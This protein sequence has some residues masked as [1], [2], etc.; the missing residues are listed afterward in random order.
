MTLLLAALVLASLRQTIYTLRNRQNNLMKGTA[1]G[2][3]MAIIGMMIHITVDFN[4]QAPAN[5]VYFV[6]ILTLAWQSRFLLRHK[7]KK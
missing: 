4:L 2:C 5:A 3:M 7:Y 1:F 6:L